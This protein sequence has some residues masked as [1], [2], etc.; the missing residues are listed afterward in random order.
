MND[1]FHA[2]D[3]VFFAVVAVFLILRLRSVLGKRTG[4]EEPPRWTR[5]P[6]DDGETADNVIDLTR[7]RRPVEAEPD[8]TADVAATAGPLARG[9]AA[10]RARDPSFSNTGFLS[11]ARMAFEM[12]VGAFAAGDKKALR[13]LLAD[14]VYKPFCDAIDARARAGEE[15]STE[16]M[17][18]KSAEIIE[19]IMV[20]TIAQVTVR[21]VSEQINVI[22]DLDGRIVEGDPSRIV[23]VTDEWTFSR[24]TRSKDPNWHL[25][26]TR[27]VTEGDAPHDA[28]DEV[29]P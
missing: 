7:A 8:V 6:K 1:G 19:A 12:I 29:Q 15:L 24:D 21:F 20:G 4:N 10:I 9:E 27:A 16:I 25:S 11:G 23:P 18:I 14:Q 2:L 26:A 3:I 17:G 13:P 5:T 22:K 28:A